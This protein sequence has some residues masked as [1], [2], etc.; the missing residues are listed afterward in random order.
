MKLHFKVHQEDVSFTGSVSMSSIMLAVW[1]EFSLAGT[2]T[3]LSK[4]GY[5][6]FA[7]NF[8]EYDKMFEAMISIDNGEPLGELSSI[9]AFVC[10]YIKEVFRFDSST[11]IELTH[12]Q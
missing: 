1:T 2:I 11:Q 4:T 12:K 3:L 5:G 6:M 9:N 10:N 7:S 8:D